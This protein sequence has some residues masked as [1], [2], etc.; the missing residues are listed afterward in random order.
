M[1][2]INRYECGNCGKKFQF[3]Q[4]S[5]D[6]WKRKCPECKKWALKRICN[7]AV[8]DG[9]RSIQYVNQESREKGRGDMTHS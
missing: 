8:R 3:S 4:K 1:S 2:I 5:T 9:H 6:G 7:V